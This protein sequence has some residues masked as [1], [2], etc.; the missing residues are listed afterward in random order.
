M[1]KYEHGGNIYSDDTEYDF[2]ANINPLGMPENV[3]K[4]ILK[5]VDMCESYPEP[6][7]ERL[8]SAISEYENFPAENI[9]CGNGASDLIYRIISVIRPQKAFVEEPSFIEYEKALSEYNCKITS[10]FSHNAD[11]VIL[12]NPNNPTGLTLNT[13]IMKTISD[14][15]IKKNIY[16]L[17]D[18]CFLDFVRDGRS[19]SI[20]NFMN[21]RV[22]ILK[23]FTKIYAMAGLRLGYALFGDKELAEKVKYSG[24]CWN[25]S[26]PAQLAGI[27]ALK[28]T[29]YI[30]RTVSFIETERRFLF[31]NLKRIGIKAYKSET[32]FILLYT[33]KP[34][35]RLL[36]ERKIKI[37][38]CEN[39]EGLGKNYYR[40]A[41]RTHRENEILIKALED[42]FNG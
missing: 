7:S 31:K 26:V 29:D 1:K 6:Y 14:I 20:F 28:E 40:I 39:F 27:Q 35:D 17:C 22:I 41:V 11:I 8:V 30:S 33:E 21:N 15:C 34:I 24:Q 32:N 5:S 36:A 4:A 23:A 25:V 2:S 3:R 38:N 37:R 10:E 19:K 13:E 9:V 12:G 42:I 18:E 16:F